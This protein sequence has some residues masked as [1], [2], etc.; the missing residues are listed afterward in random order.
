MR[1]ATQ[2]YDIRDVDA[3]RERLA[4]KVFLTA[5]ARQALAGVVPPV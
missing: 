2:L 4:D 3:P 5:V 1:R